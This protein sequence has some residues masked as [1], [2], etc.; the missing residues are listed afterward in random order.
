MG[1]LFI[2]VYISVASAWC[3]KI[4]F[5]YEIYYP[6]PGTLYNCGSP[7]GG[8]TISAEGFIRLFAEGPIPASTASIVLKPAKGSANRIGTPSPN[9]KSS[10]SSGIVASYCT[11]S[12]V[13]SNVGRSSSNDVSVFYN[14]KENDMRRSI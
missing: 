9:P 5:D 1:K 14:R 8:G 7:F 12:N 2:G 3:I 13:G 11:M 6:R 4:I 10:S